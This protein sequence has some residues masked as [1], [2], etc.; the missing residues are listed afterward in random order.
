MRL[1]TPVVAGLLTALALAA[2]LVWL[3]PR[4]GGSGPISTVDDPTTMTN[5]VISFFEAR[6][7]RD[8]QD[9]VA[10]NRLADAYVQRARQTG[11]VADY[12]RAEAALNASLEALPEGNYDAVVQL[13]LVNNATHEFGEALR[14]ADQAI[15]I[16]PQEP[17]ALAIRGDA[18]VALGRYDEAEDA[19]QR[20]VAEAP[21][22][23]SFGRLAGLL[24][25]RGDLDTAE[26]MW[27]NALTSDN[28]RRPEST[29]WAQ[30]QLGVL[31]FN[32]GDFQAAEREHSRALQAFPGYAPARAGLAQAHAARGDYEE[33]AS[34]YEQVVARQPSPEYVAALGDVYLAAGRQDEAARQFELVAAIDQLYKAN[35]VNTDLQM[36][37]FFADHDMR[38]EEAL[39][40]A[41]EVYQGRPSIQAADTLAW[42]L[43]KAGRPEEALAYSDEALRLGTRDASMRFH[44]GMIRRALGDSEGARVQLQMALEINPRFSVLYAEMAV[45]TLEELR[46]AVRG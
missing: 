45:E 22:L 5:G 29:A 40:Q 23:S 43:Y 37:Q 20:V 36:A 42:A 44:A 16:D 26:L 8:P 4:D 21:G 38:L 27:R 1:V 25:L 32:G 15:E 30:T 11:D 12:G 17:F 14:L 6:V 34:L 35:G 33:A 39:R 13:A 10:Y 28:G 31:Y 9:F 3:G 2:I 7:E 41:R 18:L 46:V 24:E 19:Y